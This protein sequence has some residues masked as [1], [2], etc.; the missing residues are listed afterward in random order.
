MSET[1]VSRQP[2]TRSRRTRP[3]PDAL[4]T[5]LSDMVDRLI[6]ENRQL[7]RALQQVAAGGGG[8]SFGQAGKTLSG[9]QRRVARALESQS[10]S[11]RGRSAAPAAGPRTRRRITDPELLRRQ[12]E[13]LAKARA[14]R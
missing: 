12:R 14:A 8:T 7:K 9:L 6:D 10:N 11:R 5:S 2:R 4:V 1:T 13:A 3:T